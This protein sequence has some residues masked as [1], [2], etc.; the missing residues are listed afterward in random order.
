VRIWYSLQTTIEKIHYKSD[1]IFNAPVEKVWRYVPAADHQHSAF[2]TYNV[3]EQSGNQVTVKAEIYNPD[4]T[5]QTST[6]KYT[7][8][9]PKQMDTTVIGGT[10]DGARF[11]HTYTPLGETTRVELEGDFTPIPGVTEADQ[12]KSIDAF[13]TT[14]FNEDNANLQRMK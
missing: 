6:F 11:T 12:L 7:M 9:P 8:S 4:R 2:K 10:L 13:F 3:V 1:G 5:T 14:A